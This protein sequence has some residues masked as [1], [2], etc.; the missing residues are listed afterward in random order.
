MNIL[1]RNTI[2]D[3]D[4][5]QFYK[6]GYMKRLTTVLFLFALFCFCISTNVQGAEWVYY[7]DDVLGSK[8]YYDKESI[9]SGGKGIIKVWG[10]TVYSEEGKRDYIGSL[11]QGG[12]YNTSHEDVSFTLGLHVYNC[13]TRESQIISIN[14]Y[15]TAGNVISS[16]SDLSAK[17]RQIPPDS[18]GEKLYKIVCKRKK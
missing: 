12:Y 3:I 13:N 15:S 10:K 14:D 2:F 4:I 16:P 11:K 5:F 18:V 9:T 7:T 6:G 17:W 8:I 1:R